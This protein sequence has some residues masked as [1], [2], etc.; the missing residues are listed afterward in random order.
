M[1][2]MYAI[3]DRMSVSHVEVLTLT[4]GAASGAFGDMVRLE[5]GVLRNGISPPEESQQPGFFRGTELIARLCT[6]QGFVR[7]AYTS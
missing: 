3:M 4:M 2:S 5:H 6:K 1:G 7:L